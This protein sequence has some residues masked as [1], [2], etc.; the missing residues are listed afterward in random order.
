MSLESRDS[1]PSG[2]RT[3]MPV[4]ARDFKYADLPSQGSQVPETPEIGRAGL[5]AEGPSPSPSPS[6]GRPSGAARSRQD[7]SWLSRRER[8]RLALADGWISELLRGSR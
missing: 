5:L 4:R 1:S 8:R 2:G 6:L 7:S 3:R